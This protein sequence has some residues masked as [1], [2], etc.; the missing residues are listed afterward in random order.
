MVQGP[1]GPRPDIDVWFN[2]PV[3]DGATASGGDEFQFITVISE[4]SQARAVPAFLLGAVLVP[5]IGAIAIL[6]LRER[7]SRG[8]SPG[9]P[10]AP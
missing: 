5:A 8:A 3:V 7:G 4:V 2:T 1:Q 6:A 10:A 9:S